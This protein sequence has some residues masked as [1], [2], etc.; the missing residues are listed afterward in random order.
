MNNNFCHIELMTSD[1]KAARNFYSKMFAW[2]L[3]DVPGMPYT[4]LDTGVPPG[5]G[6]MQ[7]PDPSIPVC[8]SI[9]INVKDVNETTAKV[10]KMGG[11]VVKEKTEVSGMGWFAVYADPQGGVFSV[12][13]EKPK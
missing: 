6:M 1:V 4:L 10:K 9:Y 11:S 5:G 7:I 13:Q 3:S 8:W 2:K 12:W